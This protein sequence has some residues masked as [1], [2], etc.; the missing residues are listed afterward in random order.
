MDMM[1]EFHNYLMSLDDKQL[2][3]AWKAACDMHCTCDRGCDSE[4]CYLANAPHSLII[5][6]LETDGCACWN[7][8]AGI[9]CGY[10]KCMYNGECDDY[11]EH[12][13][14]C[15]QWHDG[16]CPVYTSHKKMFEKQ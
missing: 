5:R 8:A 14:N 15:E 12:C 10:C 7:E 11:H 16:T 1:K 9:C 13:L 6:K 4:T 2:A 3:V